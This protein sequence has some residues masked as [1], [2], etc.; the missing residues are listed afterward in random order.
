M[1]EAIL[2]GKLFRQGHWGT[3]HRRRYYYLEDRLIRLENLDLYM[4][5]P[6]KCCEEKSREEESPLENR[7]KRS[8]F[9]DDGQVAIGPAI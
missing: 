8:Q 7:L 3:L 2:G 5:G 6:E 9:F 1:I 4:N